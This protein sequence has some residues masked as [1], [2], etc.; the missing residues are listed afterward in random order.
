MKLSFD[1]FIIVSNEVHNYLYDY[2]NTKYVDYNSKVNIFCKKHGE[3]NQLP[4]H[5]LRGSGCPVCKSSKGELKVIKYLKENKI[6][7]IQNKKFKDC[8]FKNELPFDFYLPDFNMCI[9]Y[10]GEI[11]FKEIKNFGGKSKLLD[12][13][14]ND[15]IKNSFCENN[16]IDLLR[17]KYT[18]FDKV[19]KILKLY[20]KKYI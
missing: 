8:K 5:H 17:I 19:E 15:Q 1:D 4:N 2:T 3:F 18:Y 7:Y 6:N 11:H 13:Q 9:E 20:L 12:Y 16:N 14:R 10:D